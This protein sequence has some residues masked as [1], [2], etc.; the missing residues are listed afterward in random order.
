[1]NVPTSAV[2]TTMPLRT[3]RPRI[4]DMRAWR[5][6]SAK[7]RGVACSNNDLDAERPRESQDAWQHSGD[8][9]FDLGATLACELRRRARQDRHITCYGA[10]PADMRSASTA[11]LRFGSMTGA[12]AARSAA[13]WIP[14]HRSPRHG[15]WD[16]GSAQ[17][18]G[19]VAER[20]QCVPE[21][22]VDELKPGELR[23]RGNACSPAGLD[24]QLHHRRVRVGVT[25][26]HTA[27][28][29]SI[30]PGQ[31]RVGL[32]D[33]RTVKRQGLVGPFC[34]VL[35]LIAQT[36]RKSAQELQCLGPTSGHVQ[37][38]HREQQRTA[39][40]AASGSVQ[41]EPSWRRRASCAAA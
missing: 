30:D 14:R 13:Q 40:S 6:S 39:G 35:P 19:L 34:P 3:G 21:V 41:R 16:A 37:G 7:A 28:I 17:P 20:V 31:D 10:A 18:I 36:G 32:V 26:R 29:L 23:R 2:A 38:K 5:L 22:T 9:S 4:W 24:E 27:R 12:P 1:M 33:D 25:G 8:N 15:D 11:R